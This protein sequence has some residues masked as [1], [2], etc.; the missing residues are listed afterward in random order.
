MLQGKLK[1]LNPVAVTL[2]FDP[3]SSVS[4]PSDQTDDENMVNVDTYCGQCEKKYDN[5]TEE[6]LW[7]MCDMYDSWYCGDCEGVLECK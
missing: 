4:L 1:K 5:V 7:I 3:S 2:P 6:E